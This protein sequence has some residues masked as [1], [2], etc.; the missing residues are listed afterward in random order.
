MLIVCPQMWIGYQAIIGIG[1]GLG[2]QQPLIAVQAVL[3]ISQVP[4]GTS[5]VSSLRLCP[6]QEQQKTDC[7]VDHLRTNTWRRSLRVYWAKH[8]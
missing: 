5:I 8:I 3:D 4:I 2:M 1:I 6:A 7:P